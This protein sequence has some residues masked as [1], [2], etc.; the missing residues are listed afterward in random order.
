M[1]VWIYMPNFERLESTHETAQDADGNARVATRSQAIFNYVNS[2][3]GAGIIG[4]AF[5]VSETGFGA[6]IVMLVLV[7]LSTDYTTR[8][9]IRLGL[10]TGQDTYEDLME[11]AYGGKGF[12]LVSLFMFTFAYGAMLA[13]LV[14][15]G[16]ILSSV[17][18]A[19]LVHESIWTSRQLLIFLV[20]VCGILPLCLLR[21]MAS[22]GWSSGVSILAVFVM[23]IIVSIHAPQVVEEAP[24]DRTDEYDWLNRTFFTGVG[25]MFFAFVCHHSS[26][27]V[28][29]SLRDASRSNWDFVTH[30]SIALAFAVSL[31]FSLAGYLSFVHTTAADLLNNFPDTDKAIMV[32]RV[33]LAATMVFTYP[34][35][36]F[37]A[38]RVLLSAWKRFH[39]T[40][41]R[42]VSNME[43]YSSTALL[44]IT[45]LLIAL[46]TDN[47]GF[48]LS[49][50]LYARRRSGTSFRAFCGSR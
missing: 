49:L 14:I 48:I 29:G 39:G 9:I 23:V 34:M 1:Q 31:A 28:F 37:V 24:I 42:R 22:L 19:S 41:G 20:A 33:L 38:R 5:S 26:F 27:Q 17:L 43:H 4:L 16:D 35:E 32:V 45:S 18:R 13:Y 12:Y 10:L 36:N 47:L 44:F 11:H 46:S 50:E 15:I 3:V 25:G 30:I 2:I 6:G 40:H 21:S 7:A 8:L